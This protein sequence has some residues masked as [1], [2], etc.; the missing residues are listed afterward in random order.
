[1]KLIKN[2]ITKTLQQHG[3]DERYQIRREYCRK[4]KAQFV[5]RF[6]GD[7]VGSS[8]TKEEA[9]LEAMGHEC[10]RIYALRFGNQ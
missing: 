4:N 1:M 9:V 10:A 6:C 7:W 5:I 2:S 8:N 3:V